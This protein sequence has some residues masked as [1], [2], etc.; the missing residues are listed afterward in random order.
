LLRGLPL[1]KRAGSTPGGLGYWGFVVRGS[2]G[3]VNGYDEIRIFRG[4]VEARSADHSGTFNDPER[5]L[6]RFLLRSA[7]GHVTQSVQQYIQSE[8][9]K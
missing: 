7:Y 4:T 8:I 6:E 3:S 2:N 5:S 9:A 1:V